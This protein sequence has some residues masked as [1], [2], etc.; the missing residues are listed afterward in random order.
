MVDLFE[1]G[2]QPEVSL[3]LAEVERHLVGQ[4][5]QLADGVLQLL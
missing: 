4:G 2:V 3:I 5:A 1:G